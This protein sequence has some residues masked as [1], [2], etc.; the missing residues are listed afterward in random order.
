MK[1]QLLTQLLYCPYVFYQL[2]LFCGLHFL[3]NMFSIKTIYLLKV[4]SLEV[5]FPMKK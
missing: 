3:L 4:D 5:V 1:E 2:G